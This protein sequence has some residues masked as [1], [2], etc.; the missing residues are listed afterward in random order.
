MRFI[1]AL[2]ATLFFACLATAQSVTLPAEVK[3]AVGSWVIVAP[4]KIDGGKPRWRI[5]PG[6]QEVRLDLL[7]PPE[8]LA[9]L[10][11]KVVTAN[12]PGRYKLEAWNAKADAASEISTCWVV[13]GEPGPMPPE[14]KPPEPKPP[15]PKPPDVAPIP[16]DGFRVLIVHE[17]ADNL[18]PAQKAILTAQAV[19]QYLNAKCVKGPDGVTGE[20]RIWDKDIDASGDAKHWQDALKRPRTGTPWIVIST[21]RAGFEG[22]LPTTVAE[23]LTLL[24]KWGGE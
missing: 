17:S 12:R 8:Q 20:W 21:G 1:L 22:P 6:L 9:Q 15:E 10:R 13:I 3:G 4:E 7:L 16:L 19:R 11:G 24:K 23:T 5:D 2:L 18:T 14:P